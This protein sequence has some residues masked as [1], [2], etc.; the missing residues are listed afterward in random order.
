[1]MGVQTE[2]KANWNGLLQLPH[3]SIS[4]LSTKTYGSPAAKAADPSKYIK[5]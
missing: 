4:Y 2:P 3:V 1:M 5:S